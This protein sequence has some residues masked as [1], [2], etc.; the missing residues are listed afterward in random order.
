MSLAAHM[1]GSIYKWNVTCGHY[2]IEM[3]RQ[4]RPVHCVHYI[5]VECDGTRALYLAIVAIII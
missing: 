5:C 2:P 3:V 4:T 1:D